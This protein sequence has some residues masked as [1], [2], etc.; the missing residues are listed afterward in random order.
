M[1]RYWSILMCCAAFFGGCRTDLAR[2]KQECSFVEQT[3]LIK[4]DYSGITIPPNIA[5]LNFS[6]QDSFT[7]SV[8]EISSVNDSPILVKG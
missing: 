7:A 5:P 1:S 2:I 3:P 4:P 6:L 8:A